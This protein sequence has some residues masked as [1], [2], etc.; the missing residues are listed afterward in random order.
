MTMSFG[1]R[2]VN[3]TARVRHGLSKPP[4][5][6]FVTPSGTGTLAEVTRL[7]PKTFT[8]TLTKPA[9]IEWMALS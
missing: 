3:R 9:K 6:V 7:G 5:L 4:S 8:T 1:K 2:I